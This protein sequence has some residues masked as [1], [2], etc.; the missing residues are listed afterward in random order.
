M[1]SECGNIKE[2]NKNPRVILNIRGHSGQLM[3]NPE[4][5]SEH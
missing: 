3:M 5:H 4:I 1:R 2:C